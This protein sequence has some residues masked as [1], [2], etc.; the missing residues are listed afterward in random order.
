MN[1]WIETPLEDALEVLIDYR[2]KSPQKSETG[3]PVISAKVVKSGRI[4]DGIEQ[5]IAPE[6]YADWMRRGLPQVGDVVMTTE[7]PLGE[8]ARLDETSA[9]YA[10][11]QRIVT[12]RGRERVLDNGFLKYLLMSSGIQERLQSRATGS[13]VAGISQKSLRSMPLPLAPFAEQR[14]IASILGALDDKIE[15]NRRMS[16]TLEDMARSL[17][18]S[19]FVDFDPVHAKMEGRQPAYM[20]EA[21]AALFP[22]RFGD[23]GLPEGWAVSSI[24]EISRVQYGAPFKSSAFNAEKN[25]RPLVR[26]RDLKNQQAGVYTTETHPKEYLIQPGDTVVGMDGDFTPY[27]W[28]AEPSLMNQRICCFVPLNERD[29]AFVRLAIPALLKAEEDAAVATTVIHL[30]KKDIDT[31]SVVL[32]PSSI[33][34]A[35]GQRANPLLSKMVAAGIEAKTLAA[36]RDSLLPKLMSGELRVGDARNQI[37]EVA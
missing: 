34:H 20:D 26:I 7:G 9:R 5:T 35:F 27:T 19:W 16:A 14:E 6:Y 3:I 8:V 11:G 33:L 28:C 29:H 22:D 1:G 30:G 36:L 21:T 24:Y 2:G 10:L 31:F 4:L 17:Y 15:L 32:P 25:G 23:D 37:E 18:R 12:M 13:T